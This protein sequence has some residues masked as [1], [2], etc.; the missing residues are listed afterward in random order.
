MLIVFLAAL[1]A[2]APHGCAG[3]RA[4]ELRLLAA[5]LPPYTFQIPPVSVADTPG[6]KQ[7]WFMS[8]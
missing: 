2:L 4:K 8:W 1:L 5:E 3:A 6:V 7:G